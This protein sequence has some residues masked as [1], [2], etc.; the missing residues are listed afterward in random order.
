MMMIQSRFKI[1]RTAGPAYLLRGG[2]RLGRLTPRGRRAH[3]EREHGGGPMAGE[4]ENTKYKLHGRAGKTGPPAGRRS[5]AHHTGRFGRGSGQNLQG[6]L[7]GTLRVRALDHLNQ[8]DESDT[9]RALA[10][11]NQR[12]ES[13]TGRALAHLNQRDESNTGRA[14]A[15]LTLTLPECVL[16]HSGPFFFPLFFRCFAPPCR[17]VVRPEPPLCTVGKLATRAFQRGYWSPF[18]PRESHF[19]A[20]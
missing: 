8:R 11:L 7:A 12:D 20:H 9:G 14:L 18:S 1:M 10:H 4:R 13:N 16:A 19:I 2:G 6:E 15:T 17:L 3:D 5:L